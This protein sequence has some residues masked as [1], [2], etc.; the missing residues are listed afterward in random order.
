M[1]DWVQSDF[2]TDVEVTTGF[3]F[4]SS[5]YTTDG[6]RLL[7]G[8]NVAQ[9]WI[10]WDGVKRWPSSDGDIPKRYELSVGDVILAMDR[11]WIEAGLKY[12]TLFEADVPALL[13]QRV[14][15]LR[16]R[17]GLDTRF[18][19]YLIASQEFT[20]HVLGVQ[21]GT[22]VP[23]ISAGQI[24]LFRYLRPPIEEQRA[25]ASVLGAL[26]DKIELNRRMNETLEAL[27]RAIFT[28]WFVDFDPVRAKAEG[29]Q[30]VGMDAETASLFPDS[31]EDSTF[32]PIPVGWRIATFGEVLRLEYGKALKAS[33]RIPGQVI[34]YG[35]NGAVGTHDVALASG[36]GIVVG[37][38]G[39]AG[40]VTWADGDFFPIDTTFYV[41]PRRGPDWLPFLYWSLNQSGLHGHGSDSAVPGLNRRTAEGLNC[42]IPS[43]N[44]VEAFGRWVE[45]LARR[46]AHARREGSTLAM[47]RDALLPKLVS[48]EI[49]I[50][51]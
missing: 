11:P 34:V 24:G 43:G 46:S 22:A 23:H 28:S 33:D 47:L 50:T 38:K 15:R 35:S 49:R 37:R 16:G 21:T 3:P 36:P 48:G 40:S 29:R 10:R 30:P 41:V 31:F 32:G 20:N 45:P 1:S 18:L 2:A 39:T 14:A 17:P 5:R 13:V 44:E 8:D 25:I 6:I 7:R 9:G 26:D 4:S 19:G 42:V 51:V 27:A 12:A